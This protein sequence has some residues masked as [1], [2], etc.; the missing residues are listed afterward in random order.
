MV[1]SMTTAWDR[2]Y[3]AQ[4]PAKTYTTTIE[5]RGGDAEIVVEYDYYKGSPGRTYGPPEL[6][7]PSEPAHVEI[8]AVTYGGVTITDSLSESQLES[9]EQ[10]IEEHLTAK[11]EAD[12][13]AYYD[14]MRDERFA[15]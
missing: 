10:E 5:L 15:L 2:A 9:L 8:I 11:A 3:L 14:S 4:K 7:Y 1:V 6:C 13:C 12:Q